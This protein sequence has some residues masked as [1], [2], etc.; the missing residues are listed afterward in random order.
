[1]GKNKSKKIKLN[2]NHAFFIKRFLEVI[3]END[4]EILI[5]Y[6]SGL[7]HVVDLYEDKVIFMFN[8]NFIKYIDEQIILNSLELQAMNPFVYN[9]ELFEKTLIKANILNFRFQDIYQYIDI[10]KNFL[11]IENDSYIYTKIYEELRK[12][13]VSNIKQNNKCEISNIFVKN[14]ADKYSL[15]DID[16]KRVENNISRLINK[17]INEKSKTNFETFI[18]NEL[19]IFVE[20]NENNYDNSFTEIYQKI[21]NRK[22]IPDV[23]L[24]FYNSFLKRIDDNS[25][26]F[27]TAI[28]NAN[29]SVGYIETEN[30]LIFITKNNKE[31]YMNK[32]CIDYKNFCIYFNASAFIKSIKDI[33]KQNSDMLHLF[34]YSFI[35]DESGLNLFIYRHAI[36]EN[37]EVISNLEFN[38]CKIT[39]SSVAYFNIA[40]CISDKD[41]FEK[42]INEFKRKY[43]IVTNKISKNRT[44]NENEICESLNKRKLQQQKEQLFINIFPFISSFKKHYGKYKVSINYFEKMV[45]SNEFV[46][47]ILDAYKEASKGYTVVDE[48]FIKQKVI[49]LLKHEG[50]ILNNDEKLFIQIIKNNVIYSDAKT[51]TRRIASYMINYIS[52]KRMIFKSIFSKYSIEEKDIYNIVNSNKM[53][54]TSIKKDAIRL[55]LSPL[56]DYDYINRIANNE[57]KFIA[58]SFFEG[59]IA[60]TILIKNKLEDQILKII[61]FINY[62]G[63]KLL[64]ENKTLS[65]YSDATFKFQSM[66]NGIKEEYRHSIINNKSQFNSQLDIT[67]ENKNDEVFFFSEYNGTDKLSVFVI[68][69]FFLSKNKGEPLSLSAFI[70]IVEKENN[71]N[72]LSEQIREFIKEKY[73]I[74]DIMKVVLCI[75]A[76]LILYFDSKI[77]ENYNT[78]SKLWKI[79]YKKMTLKKLIVEHSELY[80]TMM[81]NE[82]NYEYLNRLFHKKEV[83]ISYSLPAEIAI[84]KLTDFAFNNK[85][86]F[87]KNDNIFD[88]FAPINLVDMFLCIGL[89]NYRDAEHFVNFNN[90]LLLLNFDNET[91]KDNLDKIFTAD[92]IIDVISHITNAKYKRVF[93]HIIAKFKDMINP[94]VFIYLETYAILYPQSKN[95]IDEIILIRDNS[96]DSVLRLW[97]EKEHYDYDYEEEEL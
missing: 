88:N 67:I 80:K 83:M 9:S 2:K 84:E 23:A 53:L 85:K 37:D 92:N 24:N 17:Y 61:D 7:Y 12:K 62:I 43:T 93:L 46:E 50:Y 71:I 70:D 65:E 95:F 26:E 6:E 90:R 55:L 18:F 94:T 76:L 87:M 3:Y 79:T 44:D 8:D 48:F 66:L 91:I 32:S 78:D 51:Q 96:Y 69:D 39:K 81:Y 89:E 56:T 77:L 54:S 49:P 35:E 72:R 57:N 40:E 41:V 73:I 28:Y 31:I 64:T 82:K 63:D 14:L 19:N 75:P 1:M 59:E 20:I 38:V 30:F 42:K 11:Y 5:E 74:D 97:H 21:D 22:L 4:S 86:N 68:K 52:D 25:F 27:I 29:N 16:I 45:F 10:P 13:I 58:Y 34:S 36:S 15:S 60:S 47:D 33:M